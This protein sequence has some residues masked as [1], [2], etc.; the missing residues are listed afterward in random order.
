M[1][2]NEPKL[3]VAGK[4]FITHNGKILV[5]RESA[6]Y[7]DGTQAGKYD[8]VGG[9]IKPG[10]NLKEALKREVKEETGLNVE[11]GKIFAVNEWHPTV[12]GE[13]WHIIANFFECTPVIP[14]AS[15][16]QEPQITLSEDHDHFKWITPEDYKNQNIIENIHHIF[17]SYLKK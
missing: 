15:G 1:E 17:E 10:E 7:A 16:N 12:K 13:Q 2:K 3:F 9:R 6:E 14:S 11:V 8:V 4:A 5:V